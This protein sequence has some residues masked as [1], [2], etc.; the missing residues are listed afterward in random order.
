MDNCVRCKSYGFI[1]LIHLYDSDIF[2][3]NFILYKN[4]TFNNV[5]HLHAHVDYSNR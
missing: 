5:I 3:S 4:H 2:N 1:F